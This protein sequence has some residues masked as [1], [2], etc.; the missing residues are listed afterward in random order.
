MA[1]WGSTRLFQ[2]PRRAGQ[3]E[4]VGQFPEQSVPHLAASAQA[5]KPAAP[6]DVGAVQTFRQC[7]SAPRA[8]AT[9]VSVKTVWRQDLRQGPCALMMPAGICAGGAELPASL[10]RLKP[11]PAGP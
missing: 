9:P 1:R 11:L 6:V 4:K 2:L 10:P 8:S 5:S 3:P 7:V